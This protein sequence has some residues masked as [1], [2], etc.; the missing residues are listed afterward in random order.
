M[1]MNR[2][3]FCCGSYR[4]RETSADAE[5]A[6]L[7]VNAALAIDPTLV[8][9]GDSSETGLPIF[10]VGFEV[11]GDGLTRLTSVWESTYSDTDAAWKKV[12]DPDVF[13]FVD[14]GSFADFT[15]VDR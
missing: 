12:T 15:V 4:S 8:K 10:R 7:A 2:L 1:T 14:D 6:A 9:V 3:S 11:N 5:A 13:P